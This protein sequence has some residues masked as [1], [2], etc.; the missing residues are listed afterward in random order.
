[1]SNPTPN[2]WVKTTIGDILRPSRERVSP[3]EFPKL[4]YVG[5]EDIEPHS[6][7]LLEHK[8]ARQPRSSSLL[9]A[10]GDILY[11]KMRPYLN[12]VWVADF[13]GLCSAEF[14]IFK[15][16]PK[17]SSQFVARRLNAEDFVAFANGKVSGDRPRV[18][19]E[20]LS[21]FPILL[22]P[23]AEQYRITT[24]LDAALSSLQR[25]ETA[26]RR[27]QKRIISYRS[28]VL[29][30][31]ATGRLT[32]AWRQG[33]PSN[34]KLRG[35]TSEGLLQ[36]IIVNRRDLWERTELERLRKAGKAPKSAK[37]KSRYREPVGL[38]QESFP[39][40][41]QGW[42]WARLEQLGFIVGGLTKNPRRKGFRLKLPYLRVAN[43][44]ADELRLDD[45]ETIGVEEEEQ[46]KLLLQKGDLLI[47]E[48][49]GSKDQIG[50]LA[51]WDGSIEKC[52]HQNHIIKV[53]LVDT[54]LGPW[55]LSWLLSPAGREHVEK[56]A[57]STTGLYTLS[58]SKV[59]NLPIPLPPF[60]EQLQII[61]QT[62]QRMLAASR[63]DSTVRQQLDRATA[64]RQSLMK[65]A[66]SGQLVPQDPRD[67]PA[68]LLLEELRASRR[69]DAENTP[70]SKPKPKSNLVLRSL[71]DVLRE[72][73]EPMTPEQLFRD[74][75]YQ[76][77]FE[78]NECR[79][80]IVDRFYEELRKLV[81]QNGPVTERRPNPDTV[82]LETEP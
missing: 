73:N 25:A 71:L 14:L 76:W 2:G 47:V 21:S 74:S 10:K 1:M 3:K 68:A 67:E 26:A 27:A 51:I 15:E 49:N 30:A 61:S 42:V 17:L 45:V 75:G 55:I 31:A 38:G 24:K 5:L 43:V 77:E 8:H 79:Q 50:R 9:F 12:K 11:G 52:V 48:G 82:L 18:D 33:H 36:R 59:G 66:F 65:E 16:N 34:G 70:M 69:K 57:S 7:R 28:A 13:D 58:I 29:N 41:P 72:H 39:S 54:R 53:R 4:R 22:P 32:S 64:A 78:Q 81:G 20:K 6:M 19:F 23:L 60:A 44:Y 62:E 35:E 63:L 56:V 40:T 37:W 46:D 80:E